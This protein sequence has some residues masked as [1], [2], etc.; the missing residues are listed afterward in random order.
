MKAFKSVFYFSL[1]SFIFNSCTVPEDGISIGLFSETIGDC[2][3]ITLFS[4]LNGD[5]Q[6]SVDEPIVESF[7][8]CD[9]ATGATGAD[10]KDG[11]DGV[12]LGVATTI[13]NDDCRLL[14]FYKDIN[15]NGIRDNN[16]EAI[17]TTNICNGDNGASIKAIPSTVTDCLNGGIKYSFY[18]DLNNNGVLDE[19]ELWINEVV[20]CNGINGAN[21]ADGATGA[22]GADGQDGANGATGA[23]GAD[24]QDGADGANGTNGTS[25]SNGA[26]GADGQDGADG[27]NGTNGTNGTNGANGTDGSQIG[28]SISDASSMQCPSPVGGLVFEVF[29]D[30]NLDGIKDVGENVLSTTIKC[31]L[32][33]YIGVYL[34]LNGVTVIAGDGAVSGQEYVLNGVSYLVAANSAAILSAYSG[35]RNLAT[36]VTS[37]V[38]SMGFLFNV[39]RTFNENIS[40]WDTSN[41]TDMSYMFYDADAF[42]QEIGNWNTSSVTTMENMF[43][44]ALNFNQDISSWD[45]SSVTNMA[46]MFDNTTFFNQDISSWD[47]SS[48]TNM[49]SMFGNANQFNQDLSSWCVFRIGTMPPYFDNNAPAWTMP[50]SR[51]VWGIVGPHCF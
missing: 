45:T 14:T 22:T 41:V 48:V 47:T 9:G 20:I 46:G 5:N 31:D 12:T 32:D 36:V 30:T 50:A 7:E 1:L 39:N 4:D 44:N 19:N 10:G 33:S 25:G 21:G 29:L 18:A 49:D 17:S 3:K 35:G 15:L 2:K 38:T 11:A 8:I 16:E 27:A 23:T 42:V 43:R 26:D 34:A 51:P 13:V 40:S 28:I 24:G 37:K 6:Y